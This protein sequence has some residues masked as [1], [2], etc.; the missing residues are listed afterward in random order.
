MIKYKGYTILK[1]CDKWYVKCKKNKGDYIP[2]LSYDG[3]TMTVDLLV[4]GKHTENDYFLHT[5]KE[6]KRGD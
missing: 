6:M 4:S 2:L 5:E 3:C 1:S